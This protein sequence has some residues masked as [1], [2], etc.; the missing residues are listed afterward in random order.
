M[1]KRL[2][3]SGFIWTVVFLLTLMN[4]QNINAQQL[5]V[6]GQVT[7]DQTNE[8]LAGAT[9]LEKGTTN[10]V[11]TDQDG[12]YSITVSNA[13]AALVFSFVGMGT[14]ELVVGGQHVINVIMKEDVLLLDEIVVTGYQSQRRG[15]L[16]GAIA[17]VKVDETKD[18]ASG[19]VLQ[20]IQGKVAGL[21][22]TNDG[23]PTGGANSV[24]VRGINTLGNTDPLYIIDG[25]PTIDP[26]VFQFM[27]QNSIESIQVLKDA[28][29]ASIYGARA[30][31]GVIIVTTKSGNSKM[32]VDFHTSYSLQNYKRRYDMANTM[33]YGEILWRGYVNDGLDPNTDPLYSYDWHMAGDVPT[34]DAVHP[35]DF[36]AGDPTLPS[37]DTDWQEEVFQT[38]II[39]SNSL[40]I[41]GGTDRSSTLVNLSYF[42]NKGMIITTKFNKV[43]LRV[44]NSINFLNNKVKVG[45]NVE[46]TQSTET[47]TPGDAARSVIALSTDILPILPVYKTDGTFAGPLGAGF[48]DRGNPVHMAEINKDDKNSRSGVFGDVYVEITPIKNLVFKST[49]GV[50]YG[51]YKTK[52]ITPT[53]EEGFLSQAI[54]S[55]DL[56]Q[57]DDFNWTW[58]NTLTYKLTK[59]SSRATFLIGTEAIS[60]FRSIVGGRREVFALN[61]VDYFY[62]DAGTGSSTN[63]GSATESKLLSYFGNLNY[64]FHDRYMLSATIR[65]DGSSRFGKNNRFGLFPAGS[66]AWVISRENFMENIKLLS[67]L[68]LRVGYGIVGNQEIGNYSRFQLWRPDYVGDVGFFNIASGGTAYDLSGIDTGTLPSGF[69]SSQSAN[70]D[71]KWESTTELNL[72]LDF[73]LLNQKITGSFDYFTRKTKDILT[74][75]P[76][77]GVIGE[78][79]SQV[80]NGATMQNKGWEFELGYSDKKG[81]I[82]YSIRGNFSHFADEIT[83]LPESVVRNYAGNTEQTIIGHSS[84]SMFGYVTDGLFQSQPEV[85]AYAAQPGKGIGRIRYKDLNKDGIIDQLDQ[86]WLGTTNPK[87][88]YGVTG[89]ISYK[90]FS[91]TIFFRGVQ[92]TL[93]ED[94][95]KQ[96]KNSFLGLLAGQN[97]GVS[98]LDAWTPHNTGSTIPMLSFSNNN[99]EDRNSDYIIVNGS[100]FK[101]QT[102]QLNY[103]LPANIVKS[104]KLQSVRF[105]CAGENLVLLFDKKGANAFTGPDPETP[106][107]QF[108]GY[109]KPIKI[110]FGCDISL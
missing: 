71:L 21:Y 69:R 73:G 84:T 5:T 105:F 88:I 77:L 14:Q 22:V 35:I 82:G 51:S 97:K 53:W 8:P 49:F 30:S 102:L 18:V 70:P 103:N 87:L 29:A 33:Q 79:G 31:N 28:S 36:I 109:P 59:G 85:D 60:N 81:D 58:S 78:G 11:I 72:G 13:N 80:V 67:N 12:K 76:Y 107:T 100:F 68:K 99:T 1:K 41:S 106:V 2:Q 7:M 94:M 16:T 10:G 95:A 26:N 25:I 108:T 98:L 42:Y 64:V 34:L 45:E 74:T 24:I 17:I 65:Y 6:T 83:Y 32:K 37:G 44:N 63:N 61:D 90:N 39:S 3:I 55:L 47:P 92:G 93:V 56:E 54:N 46:L 4:V 52:D 43:N 62:L 75:P 101:L 91:L 20:A 27:D 48:S 50:E 9:V 86:D 110:T 66:A 96:E 19:S 57:T 15:D 89:E 104:I 40:S 38:G 23:S